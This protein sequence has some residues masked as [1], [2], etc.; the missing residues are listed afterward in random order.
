MKPLDREWRP[1][2]TDRIPEGLYEVSEYGDVWSK[3]HHRVLKNIPDR[4]GYYQIGLCGDTGRYFYRI[5]RLVA[6][7]FIGEPPEDMENPTVDHI[8]DNRIND[9]YTNLRWKEHRDNASER[10]NKG[11]G[12]MNSRAVLKEKDVRYIYKLLDD[13]VL[14][15][16]QI[17]G[18]YG[19]TEATIRNIKSGK[20][21]KHLY[22]EV[23]AG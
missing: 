3:R 22:N 11:I 4:N 14:T 2:V 19:V 15:H 9:H 10:T 8:D 17:G 6:I 13:G 1:V 7:A 12:E 18:L 21:W 20:S 16:E 23:R 5:G